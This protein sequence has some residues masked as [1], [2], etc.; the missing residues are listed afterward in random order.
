MVSTLVLLKKPSYSKILWLPSDF[1]LIFQFCQFGKCI[2]ETRPCL[3]SIL[4]LVAITYIVL[5]TEMRSD[6]TRK[7]IDTI[8]HCA[9]PFKMFFFFF[10]PSIEKSGLP[11]DIS[12]GSLLS[13][14]LEGSQTSWVGKHRPAMC[15]LMSHCTVSGQPRRLAAIWE[16]QRAKLLGAALNNVIPR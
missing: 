16:Q 8:G 14:G 3:Q 1:L 13:F 11:N 5:W 7:Q 2:S 4:N 9:G 12:F 10:C 15:N 6:V